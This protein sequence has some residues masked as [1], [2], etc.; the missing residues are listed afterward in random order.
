MPMIVS[1][2]ILGL[3]ALALIFFL[4]EKVRQYSIKATIIKSVASLLFISLGAWSWY[5]SGQ[6]IFGVFVLIAL[7]CGL[8]GDIW[9]E[10]KCVYN[11]KDGLYSYAGFI[12]F[13]VGHIFYIAGMYLEFYEPGNILYIIIPFITGLFAAFMTILL[14]KPLKLQY[15]KMKLISLIY[16]FFLFSMVSCA[17]AL[18]ILHGWQKPTLIMVF[19]GGVLFALSDIILCTTYFGEGHEKPFDLCINGVLYYVAQFSIAYSL[20]FINI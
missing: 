15:G 11:D 20:M 13:A 4:C 2:V 3:G 18:T 14:E 8:L 19:G 12:C 1:Y 10:L 17:L 16:G 5:S 6:H 7:V 9:L